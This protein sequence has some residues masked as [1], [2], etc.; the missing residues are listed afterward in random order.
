MNNLKQPKNIIIIPARMASER[1]PGKP[2]LM[3]GGKPLVH[4]T[5]DRAKKT[6][7]DHVIVTSPDREVARYCRENGLTFWPSSEDC[8]TGTHRCADVLRYLRRGQPKIDC[9]VNW[10][11]DEPLADP[12][13]VDRMIHLFGD[14]A[15]ARAM[16]EVATLVTNMPDDLE[17]ELADPRYVDGDVIKAAVGGAGDAY[18]FSR[19]PMLG[20]CLHCGVY[21]FP[22]D[23]LEYIGHL[24]PTRLSQRESLEQLTWIEEALEIQTVRIGNLPPSINT[25]EDWEMFKSKRMVEDWEDG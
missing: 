23:V 13:A 19:A 25:L 9:V 3:A 7:A 2:M 4:W 14:R 18:W 16:P 12:E 24:Q 8:Q 11:V 10:Q 6:K 20:A 17:A 5:H 21:A 1:L 22:P 15:R